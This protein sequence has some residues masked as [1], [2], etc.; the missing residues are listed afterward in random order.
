MFITIGFAGC[1]ISIH[2]LRGEGDKGRHFFVLHV[3]HFNPR[4]PWGGRHDLHILLIFPSVISIHALRVEG[5]EQYAGNFAREA[6][7]IHALRVEG[8]NRL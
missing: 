6:I 1:R 7:S 4:P 3:R 5:D 8:D 2:A